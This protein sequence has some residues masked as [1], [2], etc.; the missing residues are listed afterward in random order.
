MA[1]LV[2]RQTGSLPPTVNLGTIEWT[3]YALGLD[4]HVVWSVPF[5]MLTYAGL[6][7]SAHLLDGKGAAVEGTFIEDLLDSVSAGLNLHLGWEYP[8]TNRFRIHGQGRYEVL[9]DMQ[10]FQVGLG[11]RILWGALVPGE[12]RRR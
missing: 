11:G 6:G 5:D 8:I 3:D 10:Y 9:E 2:S 7:V 12:E 4:A 1:N